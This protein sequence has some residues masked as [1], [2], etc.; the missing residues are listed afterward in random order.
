MALVVVPPL[1]VA[2]V[3]GQMSIVHRRVPSQDQGLQRG[4]LHAV[5]GVGIAVSPRA[6]SLPGL[7]RYLPGGVAVAGATMTGAAAEALAA[8][9]TTI[10][11][12]LTAAAEA[13]GIAELLEPLGSHKSSFHPPIT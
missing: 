8:P 5:E 4:F 10:G 1:Q 2:T 12:G 13:V 3:H 11:A 7:G 6:P 9:A